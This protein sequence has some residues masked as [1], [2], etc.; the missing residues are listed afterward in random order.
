MKLL[1]KIEKLIL[2]SRSV[3][4]PLQSM[5]PFVP[6]R[7]L[8]A[9]HT[10]HSPSISEKICALIDRLLLLGSQN[11]DTRTGRA[12]RAPQYFSSESQRSTSGKRVRGLL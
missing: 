3:R 7:S 8:K 4:E 5:D 10:A 2:M 1:H 12:G 9:N 11:M 6:S